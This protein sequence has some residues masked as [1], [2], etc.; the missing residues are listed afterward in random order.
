[1]H[2]AFGSQNGKDHSGDTSNPDVG[3]F[4]GN[5]ENIT[6]TIKLWEAIAKRYKDNA[7]V[8]G[9]DLLNEPGGVCRYRTI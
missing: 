8:A 3:N 1:M 6:K 7:W 2:G 5:E 9:Y 4:F